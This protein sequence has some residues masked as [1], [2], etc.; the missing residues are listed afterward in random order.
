[1]RSRCIKGSNSTVEKSVSA[2]RNPH[3]IVKS[4]NVEL[5]VL[6]LQNSGRGQAGK[7]E[8]V[9]SF[10]LTFFVEVQASQVALVVKEPTCQCR[11]H[12]R[13]GFNLW[14]G[15]IPWKRTWQPTPVFLPGESHEQRSLAGY[16]PWCH[17]ESHMTEVA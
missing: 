4:I 7:P 6:G 13:C 3:R 14:V 11:R 1:M 12:K 17:T 5:L 10:V 8:P 16:S 2:A 15:K 9:C